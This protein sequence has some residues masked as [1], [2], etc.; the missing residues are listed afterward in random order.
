[1]RL[2][3]RRVLTIV[4]LNRSWSEIQCAAMSNGLPKDAVD[5]GSNSWSFVNLVNNG[6]MV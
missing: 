4:S 5:D 6:L 1:M 3:C 2:E